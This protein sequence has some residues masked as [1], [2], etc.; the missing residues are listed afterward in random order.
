MALIDSFGNALNPPPAS[1]V[2]RPCLIYTCRRRGKRRVYWFTS[3]RLS[4][5]Q[6]VTNIVRHIFLSNHGSHPLETLYDT[7][8]RCPTRGLQNHVP[9][10]SLSSVPTWF[11]F[12]HCILGCWFV[13]WL[14]SGC[15]TRGL[16]NHVPQ[17]SPSSVSTWF[18]FGHCILGCWF[19]D[20]LY[21][22]YTPLL[23]LRLNC[24]GR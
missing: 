1:F 19:V 16:Q 3:V 4:S 24:G 9:Q 2:N 8:S 18:V 22:G 12:G 5:S 7:S 10:S 17:S 11:V 23:Q 13:D 20:W 14:Y 21:S 15:P 6:S